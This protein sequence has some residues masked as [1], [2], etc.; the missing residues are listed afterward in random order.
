MDL[1]LT[2]RRVDAGEALRIGPCEYVL[3]EGE[4]RTKAAPSRGQPGRSAD[5]SPTER[6]IAISRISGT[7]SLK[8]ESIQSS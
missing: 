6:G 8:P 4:A 1:I 5:P 3:P 7:W 2:G